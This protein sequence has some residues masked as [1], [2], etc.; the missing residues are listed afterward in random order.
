MD[1]PDPDLATH[2]IRVTPV[3]MGRDE[4]SMDPSYDS[5]AA[6]AGRKS[7]IG[8]VEQMGQSESD[9]GIIYSIDGFKITLFA[10]D[11]PSV[12]GPSGAA[13]QAGEPIPTQSMVEWAK[14]PRTFALPPPGAAGPV[15]LPDGWTPEK[16][17]MALAD[18]NALD[19]GCWV[20]MAES[21][22]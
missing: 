10:T 8:I 21:R 16:V 4:F 11:D 15:D 20:T 13:D 14:I 22:S 1:P 2:L 19:E 18:S 12:V 7:Y 3:D 17:G 6:L 5:D 9:A